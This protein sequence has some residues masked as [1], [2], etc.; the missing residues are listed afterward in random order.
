[1]S[2]TTDPKIL[3]VEQERDLKLAELREKYEEDLKTINRCKDELDKVSAQ[4]TFE[5]EQDYL[6]IDRE[7][8]EKVSRFDARR[9][10]TPLEQEVE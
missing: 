3:E 7:Y 1:M 4:R 8:E 10:M 6:K 2:L 9:E 5:W